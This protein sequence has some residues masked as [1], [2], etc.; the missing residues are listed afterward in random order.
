[1]PGEIID[2][3]LIAFAEIYP[4]KWCCFIHMGLVGNQ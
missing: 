4:E 2:Y 1:L 3:T